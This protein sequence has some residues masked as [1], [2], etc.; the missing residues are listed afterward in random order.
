[1]KD[2]AQ[3][4]P[5]DV[6][7]LKAIIAK[8]ASQLQEN[9]ESI[10]AL[11]KQYSF[12]LEQYKLAKL[13]KYA[14]SSEKNIAQ[15]NLFDE[16]G[17]PE[18]EDSKAPEAETITIAEHKR[19]KKPKRQTLPKDLPR[20]VIVHDVDVSEKQCDC[21]CQKTCIGEEVTEQ[22]EIVPAKL[23]VRCHVRPKYSCSKCKAGIA[24]APMPALLLPKS[25]AAAS[26]VAYI[27]VAKY[28]DHMPLYRQE[29][30]FER[31]KIHI[32]RNTSCQWVMKTAELA[33]PLWFL[34]KKHLVKG[35]YIQADETR[36]QVL[37]ESGRENTTNSFMWIYRGGPPGK[38]CVIYDYQPT[39]AGMHA[40]EFLDGFA[41]FLQTD[42]Y[43]GYE[44]VNDEDDIIHL[45][46]MAHARRPFAELVKI[47]KQTGMAHQMVAYMAKLYQV[48]SHAKKHSY[49]AEK[50][51]EMR[52]EKSVPI[53]AAMKIWLDKNLTRTP[54]QG[55]LGNAIRYMLARWTELTNYLLDG[56]LEIDNNLAEN[57]IRPFAVG[58]KNWMF[59]G[60]PRGAEA[61]ATLYSLI[62][63]CKANNI[64]PFEYFNKMLPRLRSC[65]TEQDFE[66]LLPF[67]LIPSMVSQ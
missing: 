50:R 54:K 12:L 6:E 4:L 21:G 15:L 62:M 43:S 57:S 41:G 47:S 65:E 45:A 8:Q 3:T 24:I 46:C 33:E 40:K 48:E 10:T 56:R 39:R 14:P 63:T 38:Q 36:L 18:A 60:S 23:F 26:L 64:E 7:K 34:L 19:T 55:K 51:H 42:G 67:N 1:M 30:T 13:R 49:T 17:L 35:D 52:Q 59:A 11:Q 31:L 27:I 16:C 66:A 22:L 28:V 2:I 9:A 32:P 25:I 20:E 44:W 5:N 58:R 29:Q 61:S 53:L 37:K